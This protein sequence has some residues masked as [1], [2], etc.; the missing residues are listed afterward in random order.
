MSTAI[1]PRTHQIS[2]KIYFTFEQLQVQC[3][4]E[5]K[6][7]IFHTELLH[8]YMH[9]CAMFYYQHLHQSD[10]FATTDDP[11]QT[12]EYQPNSTLSYGSLLVLYM[13]QFF[14]NILMCI[15]YGDIIQN[16]SSVLKI[17]CASSINFS[18]NP[19]QPLIFNYL[20]NLTFSRMTY[21]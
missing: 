15:H 3:R 18:L 1:P 12:G 2:S 17:I 14:K 16:N 9:S 5:W 10:T 13:V 19:Q 6:M 20:Y 7:Q 11:T 21:C 8:P 4:A